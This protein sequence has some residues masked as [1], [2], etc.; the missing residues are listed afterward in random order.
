MKRLLLA[1]MFCCGVLAG[2]ATNSTSATD[3]TA[4]PATVRPELTAREIGEALAETNAEKL[5]TPGKPSPAKIDFEA[6]GKAVLDYCHDLGVTTVR[7]ADDAYLDALADIT[8]T[9]FV[10][11]NPNEAA[12]KDVAEFVSLRRSYRQLISLILDKE[13]AKAKEYCPG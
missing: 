11:Q 8:V 9:A 12:A 5:G 1:A 10:L 4:A 2:C 6:T 7:E 3:V 13:T